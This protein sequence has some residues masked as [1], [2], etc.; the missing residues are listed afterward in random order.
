MDDIKEKLETLQDSIDEISSVQVDQKY[1]LADHMRRSA[2]NEARLDVME[3]I[4]ADFIKHMNQLRGAIMA[5]KWVGGALTLSVVVIQL[6][7]YM[8][9]M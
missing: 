8:K 9:G 1:I 2:A 5:F 7:V 4:R 6:I 3:D